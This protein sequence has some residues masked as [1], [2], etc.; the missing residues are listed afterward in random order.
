MQSRWNETF[1]EI[2]KNLKLF[3]FATCEIANVRTSRY[4]PDEQRNPN[5]GPLGEPASERHRSFTWLRLSAPKFSLKFKLLKLELFEKPRTRTSKPPSLVKRVL[6][7]V[8]KARPLFAHALIATCQWSSFFLMLIRLHVF[9]RT[10][11]LFFN[12]ASSFR[13]QCKLPSAQ[14]TKTKSLLFSYE[15]QRTSVWM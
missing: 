15:S 10:F 8:R 9:G 13:L 4:L 14:C 7:C 3:N 11:S 2:E 5:L 6:V 12:I 1:T